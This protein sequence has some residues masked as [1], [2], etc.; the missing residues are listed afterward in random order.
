ME[1]ITFKDERWH[2]LMNLPKEVWKDVTGYESLY[3]VSNYG[4][5]KAKRRFSYSGNHNV[6]HEYKERILKE[7]HSTT[8]YLHVT[9]CKNGKTKVFRISRLV[10]EH[11]IKNELNKPE[12]DHINT[13]RTD[14]RACNLRWVTKKENNNNPLS[15]LHQKEAERYHPLKGKHGKDV[16]Y[17]IPIIA[18]T[19]DRTKTIEFESMTD[20]SREGFSLGHIWECTNGKRK[21]HKGYK[22][23]YKDEYERIKQNI[24]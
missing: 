6:L 23:Y 5:V 22:W 15:I 8:G 16:P 18:I 9:L 2:L 11:F 20:A 12:V 17:S 1:Q 13:I 21:S 7:G 19:T 24:A 3:E 10:A 14:N 4:R